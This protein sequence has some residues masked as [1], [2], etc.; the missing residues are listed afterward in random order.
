MRADCKVPHLSNLLPGAG[1]LGVIPFQVFRQHLSRLQ[2][3][4]Q[5][6]ERTEPRIRLCLIFVY[7]TAFIPC[8]EL[9]D[10]IEID[11]FSGVSIRGNAG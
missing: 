3:A 11:G 4:M 6:T 1:N 8:L 2:N 10:N 9:V 7:R 5:G